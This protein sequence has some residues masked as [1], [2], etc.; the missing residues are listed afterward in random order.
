MSPLK[1][2]TNIIL[3]EVI[4][5]MLLLPV[6][7]IVNDYLRGM[8]GELIV[9]IILFNVLSHSILNFE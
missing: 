7:Y 3:H 2:D 1:I 6:L 8:L 4:Q 9:V 5:L